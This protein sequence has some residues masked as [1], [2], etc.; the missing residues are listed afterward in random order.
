MARDAPAM[1]MNHPF[2]DPN[3]LPSVSTNTVC[4]SLSVTLERRLCEHTAP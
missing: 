2:T 4:Q 3:S 1:L